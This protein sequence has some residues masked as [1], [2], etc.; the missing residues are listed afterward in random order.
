M[1]LDVQIFMETKKN[2]IHRWENRHNKLSLLHKWKNQ[3]HKYSLNRCSNLLR[4]WA[5]HRSLAWRT[6]RSVTSTTVN[7]KLSKTMSILATTRM[8]SNW[9]IKNSKNG[10]KLSKMLKEVSLKLAEVTK[11]TV[12]TSNQ[13][14]TLLSK[15]GHQTPNAW[16]FS[17]TLMN[18]IE[19]NSCA[20][21]IHLVVSLFSLR[22][23]Q[24]EL[25]EF[26]TTPNTRSKLKVPTVNGETGI[27]LGQDTKFKIKTHSFS[28]VCFGTLQKSSNGLIKDLS[29]NQNRVIVFTNLMLV[30]LKSSVE[31]AH[32]L[33]LLITTCKES[34]TLDTTWSS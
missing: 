9:D 14:E 13:T 34:R 32:I 2:Q 30:W 22:Q 16:S 25:Q 4:T 5:S 11:S 3:H 23:T 18:G 10:S 15:N 31:W 8:T 17:E 21:K 28:I 7:Y 12:W 19:M 1:V 27:L 24:M 33:I 20:K 6:T 29:H 26:P